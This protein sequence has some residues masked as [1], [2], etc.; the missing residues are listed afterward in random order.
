MAEL[1]PPPPLPKTQP[2]LRRNS[3]LLKLFGVGVLILVMMIPLAMIRGVLSDR[4]ER[5]DEAVS[6][7]TD[8]WGKEQNIIGPVLGVPF[9]YKFKSMKDTTMPDGHVERREVEEMLVANAFFLPEELNVVSDARTET[10]HRGIYDAAVFRAQV[11]LSGKF[12]PPDFGPLKIDLQD[13][14]W[15]DAFVTLAVS[16]LRGTR[17]GLVLDW[18]GAKHPLQPGSQLPGYTTGAT[19]LLA[20]DQPIAGASDFSIALDVNGSS[21]IYFA[22]FGVRNAAEL[23]SNWPDPGFRGAFL[24]AERSVRPDGFDAKWKVSYYGRDYPQMWTSLAGNQRFNE[25]T[26][27][28]SLFGADFLSIL[29]AYRFVERSIKYGVLF[30][31]LVFTTFFLFEVTA[32]QKIH[33][34]QYL[35]VG[36]A[37]CLFY[38]LLLSISEFVGFGLA[39]LIAAVVS[40]VLI[41]WYCNFFLGGG[42]RTLMIGAGLAGVYTFLYITLRQQDYALLMGAI[43]LFVLL[44]V[45]MFVTRRVDWYARDVN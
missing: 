20:V 22:P 45:V 41:T 44:A 15:K 19:A 1:Q 18:N 25:K 40:T 39:Y 42:M 5:R 14:L 11:K 43:A 7:I 31:V 3:T 27:N 6:A 36:A 2:F 29:D 21:G 26:V 33:P 12:A 30:L 16:D 28:A 34:F 17:E 9:R 24:P 8:S 13:V 35:M 10:L 32:R 4:L 38:L 23:K 37:L